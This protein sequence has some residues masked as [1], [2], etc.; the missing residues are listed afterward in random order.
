MTASFIVFFHIDKTIMQYI[1]VR[2]CQFVY[3]RNSEKSRDE[4]KRV[5]VCRKAI[6]RQ[7]D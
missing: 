7:K 1:I 5:Q 3:Y 6:P 2:Y 4:Q